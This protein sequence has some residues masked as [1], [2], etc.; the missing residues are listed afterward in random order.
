MTGKFMRRPIENLICFIKEACIA[1][2]NPLP[3]LDR[4]LLDAAKAFN[5]AE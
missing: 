2:L 5:Q 1:H 3:F 4:E